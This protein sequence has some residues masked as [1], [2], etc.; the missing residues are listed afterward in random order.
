MI[1]V[2]VLVV[3]VLLAAVTGMLPRLMCALDE[4]TCPVSP[5]PAASHAPSPSET[6]DPG[7]VLPS[8]SGGATGSA[9]LPVA[10]DELAVSTV[11]GEGTV[12]AGRGGTVGAQPAPAP[13]GAA[14]VIGD[15]WGVATGSDNTIDPARLVEVSALACGAPGT[16][17]CDTWEGLQADTGA[18]LAAGPTRLTQAGLDPF[19]GQEEATTVVDATLS[20]ATTTGSGQT[21]V[22][23]RSIQRTRDGALTES[24]TWQDGDS[25]RQVLTRR[26]RDGVLSSV[27]VVGI[28]TTDTG[29]F[30]VRTEIPV[31]SSSADVMEEWLAA[32]PADRSAASSMV[33][34]ISGAPDLSAP[35]A[36]RAAFRSGVVQRL[37]IE[38]TE[39]LTAQMLREYPDGSLPGVTVLTTWELGSPNE[40]G[41]RTWTT[42]EAA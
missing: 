12:P 6:M 35:A 28:D 7:S 20:Q 13:A 19:V 14:P 24:W 16:G 21:A 32:L 22:L 33:G 10:S 5:Q 9:E 27:T 18:A 17:P 36:V 39:P 37:S 25:L 34:D 3:L 2:L 15:L 4:G 41:N 38:A 26:S 23:Y 29:T 40:R 11:P 31:T 1:A 8:P 42:V 30:L